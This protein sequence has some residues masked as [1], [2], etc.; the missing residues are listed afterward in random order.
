MS[1]D[2]T[3]NNNSNTKLEP[4]RNGVHMS[5]SNLN[6]STNHNN[7]NNNSHYNINGN[8]FNN[9][10]MQQHIINDNNQN[11][12]N[13][14]NSITAEHT[15]TTY[16]ITQLVDQKRGQE[17]IK[18]DDMKDS[19]IS[20]NNTNNL[21]DGR[22]KQPISEW[23]PIDTRVFDVYMNSDSS[24]NLQLLDIFSDEIKSQHQQQPR[25]LMTLSEYNNNGNDPTNIA[26]NPNGVRLVNSGIGRKSNVLQS[27]LFE[28]VKSQSIQRSF[29]SEGPKG[30]QLHNEDNLNAVEPPNNDHSTIALSDSPKDGY[31]KWPTNVEDAFVASLRLIMKKGTS[32]TKIKDKNYGRN[33]LISLYIK[34]HTNESRTKKQI[35]SHIQVWK[36]AI[37]NKRQHNIKLTSRD[38]EIIHLIENGAEQTEESTK[39]FYSIFNDIVSKT[40]PID[41]TNS[42]IHTGRKRPHSLLGMEESHIMANKRGANGTSN[43]SLIN[44]P[45]LITPGSAHTS[46]GFMPDYRTNQHMML[47]TQPTNLNAYPITPLDYAKSIYENLKSYKCVPVKMEDDTYSAYG[48]SNNPNNCNSNGNALITNSLEQ[49]NNPNLTSNNLMNTNNPIRK[50]DALQTAKNVEQQQRLLIEEMQRQSQGPV[51]TENL[52]QRNNIPMGSMDY[53][54]RTIPNINNGLNSNDNNSYYQSM[55]QNSNGQ[56]QQQLYDYQQTQMQFQQPQVEPLQAQL[57]PVMQQGQLQSYSSSFPIMTQT[58]QPLYQH[59]SNIYIPALASSYSQSAQATNPDQP[60]YQYTGNQNKESRGN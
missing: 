15:S 47:A 4:L 13:N 17:S 2:H 24:Q 52:Y 39:L 26:A 31:D 41:E 57:Q 9:G 18:T 43:H 19:G 6:N 10:Q 14:R 49:Q 33:E 55:Y 11:N 58:H 27:E 21:D 28:K 44:Y 29:N 34:Y 37:L 40:K 25:K 22:S 48:R 23:N 30:L 8:N 54:N 50:I 45:H 1:G 5:L 3:V 32:K 60:R 42:V 7:S 36:K 20:N 16:N 51:I 38:Q 56:A 12:N 59:Q 35:S 46:N 53:S